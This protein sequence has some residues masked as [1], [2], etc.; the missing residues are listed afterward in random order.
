M[1]FV[2]RRGDAA[3]SSYR[4]RGTGGIGLSRSWVGQGRHGCLS[5][6]SGGQNRGRKTCGGVRASAER[7]ASETVG[8]IVS[9]SKPPRTDRHYHPFFLRIGH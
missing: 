2:R 7:P 4:L 5:L 3:S 9:G 6:G 8:M 1:C